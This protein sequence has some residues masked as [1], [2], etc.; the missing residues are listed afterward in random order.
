MVGMM[1]RGLFSRLRFP[2]AQ[3]PVSSVTGDLLFE[4][5]WQAVFR[6]ERLDLK[7]LYTI[8]YVQLH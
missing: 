6:L 8:F 3:F 7:V 5:F 1:V 2:Y 4:P